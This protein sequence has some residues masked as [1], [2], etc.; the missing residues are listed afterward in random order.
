MRLLRYIFVLILGSWFLTLR[1]ETIIVGHVFDSRTGEAISH[2]NI[3]YR[4][5]DIGCSTND[6]GLFML[7]T[8]LDKK[9]TLIVSAV[10]YKTQRYTV[11]PNQYAGLEVEM[12]EN[13]LVLDE[14]F[15]LPGENPA[16][17]IMEQVRAHAPQNDVTK[18]PEQVFALQEQQKLF[19]SDI[20]QRHLQRQLWKSLQQG[21]LQA[22]D[23]TYLVPLY[24]S[25]YTYERSGKETTALTPLQEKAVVLTETDYQI[26]LNG[27]PQTINFY[28]N[29]IDIFS[30]NFISPLA[31]FGSQYY[32]YRLK[33]NTNEKDVFSI[34]FQTKNP[35]IPTFNGEMLLDTATY[36]LRSIQLT[37]P[38]EVNVNYLSSIQLQQAYTPQNTLA[39]EHL[40]MIFDF[41]VKMDTTR[42]F[43]TILLQRTL[44]AGQRTKDE[45]RKT[46]E[47]NDAIQHAIANEVSD[48]AFNLD[49]V[50]IVQ[51]AK[52][53]AY[54]LNTG[55]IRMGKAPVNVGNVQEIIGGNEAEGLRLGV[56]LAT[57]EKFSKHV[58]LNGYVGYGFH[59]RA[60]KWQAQVQVKLPTD[61]RHVF[62]TYYWDHYVETDVSPID[63]AYRENSIFNGD[64]DFTYRLLRSIH[65]SPTHFETVARKQEFKVF[66]QNEWNEHIETDFSFQMGRMGYGNP[67]VGYY[68]M[69]TYRYRS[70]HAGIRV[71]WNE[72]KIDMHF[73][74][75]HL[76]S[77]YPIVRFMADF[78]SYE[79]PNTQE[80]KL[81]ARLTA[82]VQQTIP[83]GGCGHVDYTAEAGIIL[84]AVPYNLLKT[85]AGNQSWVF[86]DYRFSLMNQA[87]YAADKYILLHA[88][89]DLEGALLNRIPGIRYARLHE[90]L[91]VK[92]AWGGLAHKHAE[93]P[94]NTYQ[95]PTGKHSLT[96]PYLE[97]GIGIGNVLRIGDFY[98]VARLTNFQDTT[99]PIMGFRFRFRLGT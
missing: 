61:N 38:R 80:E 50:P 18:H 60:P 32:A 76:H 40:S 7:R 91:E 8:E 42:T 75:V 4:G 48:S 31:S 2:A 97:A 39:N 25:T 13:T 66:A 57:N 21:M 34:A 45:G 98:F 87:Q 41:A 58:R 90:L 88:H 56:P 6:E 20:N 37:V 3:Y 67:H 63:K 77:Q 94:M 27:L 65:S 44:D 49:S 71:G 51:W 28:Q 33:P 92:F 73:R 29:T 85:F 82:A 15:V 70:L 5:T 24:T 23:S 81:Y 72:K 96:I 68:E 30:K 79:L 54:I 35:F 89:W 62:G 11:E 12:Q 17:A 36:A 26:L 46:K 99:S 47:P 78:G 55:E 9:R 43:P 64:M 1:A 53:I 83:L 10:G 14:I 22:D 69:P 59:D 84:G 93:L 74:R 19:I 95:P 52:W 16:L 86:D